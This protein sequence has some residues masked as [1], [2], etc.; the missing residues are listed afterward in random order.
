MP[1]PGRSDAFE[2]EQSLSSAFWVLAERGIVQYTADTATTRVQLVTL[3]KMSSIAHSV[4]LNEYCRITF[5]WSC[6]SAS[7]QVSYAQNV[8]NLAL[9]MHPKLKKK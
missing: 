7:F 5:A 4:T 8:L 6:Q 2:L 3:E 1:I 9:K